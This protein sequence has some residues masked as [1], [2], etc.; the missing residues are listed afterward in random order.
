[1]YQ[2]HLRTLSTNEPHPRASSAVLDSFPR[3][4]ESIILAEHTG[5]VRVQVSGDL[6]ALLIKEILDGVSGH[7]DIWNWNSD[8]HFSVRTV[9]PFRVHSLT[10]FL[11]IVLINRND[12]D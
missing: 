8:P 7:L 11:V 6:I 10:G 2:L 12:G 3:T 9:V 1:M 5:G 4:A